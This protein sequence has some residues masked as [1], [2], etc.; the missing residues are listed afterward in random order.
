[1]S[2]KLGTLNIVAGG[3]RFIAPKLKPEAHIADV[4]GPFSDLLSDLRFCYAGSGYLLVVYTLIVVRL[5][6]ADR[7]MD[8]AMSLSLHCAQ[9]NALPHDVHYAATATNLLSKLV[10]SD[11]ARS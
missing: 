6:L 9:C 10:G 4:V 1:M 8:N 7:V 3:L 11:T 2:S 5:D